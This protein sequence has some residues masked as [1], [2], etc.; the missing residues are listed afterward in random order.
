MSSIVIPILYANDSPRQVRARWSVTRLKS[1]LVHDDPVLGS[2]DDAPL[3]L[4]DFGL[5]E[6]RCDRLDRR[7]L[8]PPQKKL[9]LQLAPHAVGELALVV[10]P[11]VPL[12]KAGARRTLLVVQE[13]RDDGSRGG[14][15]VAVG[16]GNG[17]APVT[18]VLAPTPLPLSVAAGLSFGAT[19]GHDPKAPSIQ[20]LDRRSGAG[21]LSLTMQNGSPRALK[22][23]RFYPECLSAPG[24]RWEPRVFEIDELE[25]G[26]AFCA[27]FPCDPGACEEGPSRVQFVGYAD[28]FDRT[29]WSMAL[30]IFDAILR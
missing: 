4:R 27:S 3:A 15:V 28:G 20:A 7:G 24:M 17:Q 1:G 14:I 19:E 11:R 13:E 30:E 8:K 5:I 10:S 6:H 29:R 23:L 21:W 22:N 18:I 16:A 12:N 9:Q 2:K 25:P 26:A